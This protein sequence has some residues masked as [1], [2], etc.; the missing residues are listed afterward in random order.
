MAQSVIGALRVN[1]GLDSAQFTRGVKKAQTTAEMMGRNLQKVGAA[2]SVVGAG[3]TLAIRGQINAA[4]NLAKTSQKIGVPVQ[5]LSQLEHAAK[6]SGVSMS[7]LETAL[8]RLSQSI[9]NDG[10]K[11]AEL[12]I[13]VRDANGQIRPTVDV[14]ADLSDV[15]AGMPDGAEKTAMAMELMGRSGKDM[16]PFLNQG[17]DA[18]RAM[19]E[20]ADRL[21]LTMSQET[22]EAAQK[23]N[24]NLTRLGGQVQGV[25]RIISAEMAPVLEKISSVVVQLAAKFGQLS[26][27]MRKLISIIAGV[28]VVLG[29]LLIALGSLVLVIGAISAP[30][31][32]VV[33]GITA[34]TAAVVA[35]WPQIKAATEWMTVMV[36][37][38]VTKLQESL[39]R[40]ATEGVDFVK[41]KFMEMVDF[42]KN[43][44]SQLADVG[45]NLMTGLRD[46]ITGAAGSAVESVGQAASSVIARAKSIFRTRSPSLVFKEIG[47]DLMTGLGLGI[48]SAESEATDAMEEVASAVNQ[49]AEGSLSA[50]GQTVQSTMESAF[51]SIIDGSKS[52][53]EAFKDMANSIMQQVVR[54]MAVR[55]IMSFIPGGSFGGMPGFANGTPNAPGGLALVGERG[56]ELVNLPKGSK[57]TDAQRTK[58]MGG[59][60]HI[61]IKNEAGGDGYSATAQAKSNSDGGLN[62]D[63]LIRRVV[64]ADIQSNGAL[65]QQM[66]STFGLRRAV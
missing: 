47:E 7:G 16:I 60:I 53:A 42:L 34:L 3:I 49:T 28:T 20:E 13:A 5:A 43:I 11:F 6:L 33:V 57:V 51:G 45:S 25:V 27:E 38:G 44:P 1:L 14:M 52:A 65:A 62:I 50:I 10:Q 24:D 21:G 61:N 54:M 8:G 15:I 58:G 40:L 35:F 31:L 2:V 59:D 29:P 30:V 37:E 56:P 9:V 63:V 39:V 48:R 55:A 32:A 12:G 18:L 26:P 19:M 36:S 66:S 17:A 23:F 22:A 4:D 41:Q 46:G 64:A